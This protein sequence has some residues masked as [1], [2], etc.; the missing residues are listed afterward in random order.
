MIVTGFAL[1]GQG[2][3]SGSW[4]DRLFGWVIPLMGGSQATHSWHHLGMWYLV[5]FTMIHIYIVIRD[6]YVSRQ[7]MISTMIDGWRTWKDDRP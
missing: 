4:A 6:Q 5:V 2:L 7:A 1:Y 3:G